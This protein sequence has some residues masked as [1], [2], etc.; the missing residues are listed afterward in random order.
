MVFNTSSKYNFRPELSF[1]GHEPL[2]V[3]DVSRLLGVMISSDLT[4]TSHV[5]DITTRAVKKLWVLIRFKNLGASRKQLVQVYQARIRRTLENSA[6]V[7]SSGLT[8]EQKRL[9]E[10]VQKKA[11]VIILGKDYVS[12]E[13]ALTILDLKRLD[14]RRDDICLNFAKKCILSEKHNS[15]FPKNPNVRPDSRHPKWFLE[16]WCSTSRYF[17]SAIPSLTRL[18]NQ[19]L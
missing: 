16:P 10:M 9:I 19:N 5:K 11:F 2:D 18:L 14:T 7:Y 1:P 3:I 15:M 17:H 8:Q 6:P 13:N 12:Y 4:W